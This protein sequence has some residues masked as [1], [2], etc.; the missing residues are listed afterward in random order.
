MKIGIVGFWHLGVVLSAGLAKIGHTVLAFDKSHS[1]IEVLKNGGLY[2]D[3]PEVREILSQEL[4]NKKIIFTSDFFDLKKCNIIWIAYD[5]PVDDLDVGDFDYVIDG[6][7]SICPY[8]NSNVTL[9]ISSQ[10][11]V[12]TAKIIRE[13]VDTEKPNNTID[14]AVSPENL[15]L[16]QAMDSLLNADRII[17]G[18]EKSTPSKLLVELF[19]SFGSKI[20][21]MKI[22]SAEMTKHALNTFLAAQITLACEIAELCETVGAN[23]REVVLGL[24][25]DKRIGNHAYVLP[26]LGFAG[27]TLARDINYLTRISNRNENN[28]IIRSLININ[29]YN[30]GWILRKIMARYTFLQEVSIIFIGLTYTANTN[31]LRRSAT[32]ELAKFLHTKGAKIFY[33]EEETVLIPQKY[34]KIFHVLPKDFQNKDSKYILVFTKKIPWLENTKLFD[35]IL[36]KSE[37]I[38]DPYGYL[39][40]RK[41]FGTISQKHVS[42]GALNES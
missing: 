14:I 25:S 17:V 6:F 27:G 10:V 34:E 22:E 9:I 36:K 20:I 13:I 12:G 30:N 39:I 16:G 11:P 1:T 42:V 24:K 33:F 18:I 15:R 41:G 35:S 19:E 23:A 38:I 4:L 32:L 8:I 40:Q 21:W 26:G 7:K 3:E 2:V 28:S 37:L 31:T 29:K 5:T